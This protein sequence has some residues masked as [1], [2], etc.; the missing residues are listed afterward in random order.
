MAR[1]PHCQ[2]NNL[3]GRTACY[4]CGTALQKDNLTESAEEDLP[5]TICSACGLLNPPRVFF[6]ENCGNQLGVRD[7][8]S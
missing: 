6:C 3:A 4:A 5:P 7:E 2:K 1:C 8:C